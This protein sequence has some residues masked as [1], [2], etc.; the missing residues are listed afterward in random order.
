M[1]GRLENPRVGNESL[2]QAKKKSCLTFLNKAPTS[3]FLRPEV[4]RNRQKRCFWAIF[5]VK[6]DFF[7][8]F[9]IPK[10]F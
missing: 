5:G 9:Q 1:S 8:R 7:G 6:V 10:A 2:H 4:D 3:E